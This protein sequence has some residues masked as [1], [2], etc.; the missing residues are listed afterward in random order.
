MTGTQIQ[1]VEMRKVRGQLASKVKPRGHYTN[2][3]LALFNAWKHTY[4]NYVSVVTGQ[5]FVPMEG[6]ERARSQLKRIYQQLFSLCEPE[7]K[8]EVQMAYSLAL[9]KL[10]R[11]YAEYA[12]YQREAA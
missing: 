5:V 11:H 3:R 8:P 6:Y 7:F 12:R 9:I 2:S 1:G 4:T 10:K